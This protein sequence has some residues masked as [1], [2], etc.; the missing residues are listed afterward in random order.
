MVLLALRAASVVWWAN[1][2]FSARWAH[3][4]GALHGP[5]RL[6]FAAALIAYT[7]AVWW[8]RRN[9]TRDSDA[10]LVTATEAGALA[11][12]AAGVLAAAFLTWFPLATWT[13]IPFLDDWVPRFQSTREFIHWLNA[14]WVAGW[15][16]DFLGGY[17]TS[18]DVTQSLGL[19]GY[20]PMMLLGDALGFHVLHVLLFAAVP[21][22]VWRDLTLGGM[23]RSTRLV[24]V[25][26]ASLLAANYSYFLIRSGDTNS[27]AGAVLVLAALVAAHAA[28]LGR[29]WGAP[30]LVSALVAVSYAHTG[31]FIYAML[32][33]VLDGALAK[34]WR[35]VVRAGVSGGVAVVAALPMTWESWRYPELFNFNNVYLHPPESI[36]W[37]A[38]ARKIFYNTELLWLPHRW[39][40]DYGGLALVLLPVTVALAVVDRSRARFHAAAAVLTVALM[41][42]N[43]PHFG[44]AFIRPIHMFVIFLSPVVA[45][46]ITR[47][48]RSRPAAW[49]LAATVA[50]YVQIWWVPVP[51]ITSMRDFNA[52]LVDRVAAAP[53]ALVLVENNPHRNTNSAPGGVTV[54]SRFGNHF[55]SLLAAE[56]GRRLYAGYWDGWQ[57]SPW[58]GQMLGGA[59]WMGQAIEE[60]P[61]ETFHHELD[62]WGVVDL[63]VWSAPS[64]A[65]LTADPRYEQIWT[66]GTW[67]QFRRA[68]AD[69]REVAVIN[70]EATLEG[71]FVGG[72]RV[73]LTRASIG[74]PVV[75]RTN[76]HPSWTARHDATQIALHD[77]GGQL[78]FQSPCTAPCVVELEYP[79]RRPL[80]YLALVV[81][82]LGM[83][84]VLFT[85][86]SGGAEERNAGGVT[87]S[88]VGRPGSAGSSRGEKVEE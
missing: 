36:N 87:T 3:V 65:Y 5:K 13:A 60:V 21:L 33:L 80:I 14:G 47:Y 56:T 86:R 73:N 41:R 20:L 42:L 23:D 4:P 40:N 38:L 28:R 15:Q 34:D 49:A 17:H 10:P 2:L 45:V 72:A 61:A 16:W 52:Q 22:L 78:A 19:L 88:G 32:Y 66:D 35:A 84:L 39:F 25:A 51:H 12:A 76:F 26:A 64:V 77:E 1:F 58:R 70:G 6:W 7:V 9:T 53:G 79:K 18:S 37:P 50:L 24:A 63:F 31:S 43:D 55:E 62:R 67:T 29:R 8:P 85:G 11:A 81:W 54:P 83:V 74:D 30:A 57:W 71:R 46:A 69:A 82:L 27:L 68:G 44:Y 75:V 48:T 59:T